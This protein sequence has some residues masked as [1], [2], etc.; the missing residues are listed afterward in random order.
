MNSTLRN[1]VLC[2]A[3]VFQLMSG[4]HFGGESSD[5]QLADHDDRAIADESRI[6][7]WLSYGRTHSERRF[8]PLTDIHTG[9]V[10]KLRVDWYM[11]LP[12]D[13]G[14]VSTPLVVDGVLYFIGTMNVVRAVDAVTGKLK[15]RYDPQVAKEVGNRKKAGWVH[16][17]GLSYSKG[18]LFLATW[19]GRLIALDILTGK[20]SCQ[21]K[22]S[23]GRKNLGK[24]WITFLEIFLCWF[25]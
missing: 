22:I 21:A 6:Q 20:P 24:H 14:L 4:S 12:E 17:R 1:Q 11:D 3:F 10:A 19:D 2:W 23:F 9:N 15:W 16:N 13:V 5:S 18:R 25:T 7:D 8:S